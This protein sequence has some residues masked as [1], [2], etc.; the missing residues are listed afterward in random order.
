MTWC[1]CIQK[2]GW[3]RERWN[4]DRGWF[5]HWW[6]LYRGWYIHLASTPQNLPFVVAHEHAWVCHVLG[7]GQLLWHFSVII[8]CE[9]IESEL[10]TFLVG[11]AFCLVRYDNGSCVM[12][13]I[14][15]RSGSLVAPVL[16]T[17]G[18]LLRSARS[19]APFEK[20]CKIK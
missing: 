18:E 16:V 13:C 17:F 10:I 4:L 6:R 12:E 5:W 20:H 8:C 2:G 11:V 15:V 9:Q 7:V 19:Q 1:G 3:W 14:L